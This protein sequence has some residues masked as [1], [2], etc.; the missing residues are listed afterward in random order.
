MEKITNN[1]K[2]EIVT[3]TVLCP[4][5]CFRYFIRKNFTEAVISNE[6]CDEINIEFSN[7]LRKICTDEQL[8]NFCPKNEI[9]IVLNM[10]HPLKMNGFHPAFMY[11]FTQFV[12]EQKSMSSGE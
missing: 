1:T 4:V 10:D 9:D 11:H 2:K 5:L 12:E 7:Y 6:D 3:N 8:K